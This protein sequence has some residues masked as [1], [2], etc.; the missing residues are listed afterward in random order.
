M[1]AAFQKPNTDMPCHVLAYYMS[2]ITP[3][4]GLAGEKRV[5]RRKL[6]RALLIIPASSSPRNETVEENP[7]ALPVAPPQDPQQTLALIRYRTLPPYKHLP[8]SQSLC[9]QGST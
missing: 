6:A 3:S 9:T 1:L 4:V 7:A 5:N 8:L 2:L